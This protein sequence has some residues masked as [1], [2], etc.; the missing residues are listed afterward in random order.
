MPKTHRENAIDALERVREL[1]ASAA[2]DLATDKRFF[3]WE[4]K[5]MELVNQL[6][7][8]RICTDMLFREQK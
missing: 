4:P 2:D 7:I 1:A 6:Q 8:V 5:V 3:Y